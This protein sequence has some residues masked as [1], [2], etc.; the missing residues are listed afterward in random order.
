MN[1]EK[2]MATAEE[3]ARMLSIGRSTFWAQVKARRL[4]QP[5]KIGGATRWRVADLRNV[6]N[7]AS[8]PT[9]ASA[10]A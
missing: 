7:P 5:V 8:S 3:A 6:G 2:I 1:E 9:T 4:P 10:H